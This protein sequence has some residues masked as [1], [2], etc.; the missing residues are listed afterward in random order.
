MGKVLTN[1]TIFRLNFAII[2]LTIG[3]VLTSLNQ[4]VNS[5]FIFSI[6]VSLLTIFL[7]I[8]GGS[9][10]LALFKK[11]RYNYEIINV[12]DIDVKSYYISDV[13]ED[14]KLKEI[15]TSIHK[16]F[17]QS[18]CYLNPDYTLDQLQIDLEIDRKMLSKAINRIEGVNFYQFL[19]SYRIKYAKKMLKKNGM[20]TLETLSNECGFYSKSSFNKYFKLFEGET[21]SRFKIKQT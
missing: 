19:A 8:L 6:S 16:W 21:P 5:V 2:L 10:F 12:N 13:N 15:L 20:Y 17:D 14:N 1:T 11:D 18:K 3:A 4:L 9:V 7:S